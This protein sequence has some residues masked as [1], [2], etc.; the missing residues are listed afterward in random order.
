MAGLV[1]GGDLA[2]QLGGLDLG[3]ELLLPASMLRHQRD[4]FLDG[5]T[6]EELSAALSVPVRLV[7]NDGFQLLDAML[8]R[9][10][11]GT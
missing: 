7:E 5:M 3:E 11:E 10:G 8:G 4:L 1:T 9:T 6:V 2:A